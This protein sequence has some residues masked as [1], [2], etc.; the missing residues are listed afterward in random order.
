MAVRR[1]ESGAGRHEAV[2]LEGDEQRGGGGMGECV[3]VRRGATEHIQKERE[4]EWMERG[5]LTE[6][7]NTA[8]VDR[9]RD[10]VDG[11]LVSVRAKSQN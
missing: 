10:S 4:K 8:D 9:G 5:R 7:E 6:Q 11:E 2:G 1:R 3:W